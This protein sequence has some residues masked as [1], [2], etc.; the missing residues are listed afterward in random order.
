MNNLRSLYVFELIRMK[1]YNILGASL[2]TSFIFIAVLHFSGVED[3][4]LIFPLLIFLDVTVM[5]ML[6]IGV[7]MFFEK[8]EGTLK[9]MLVSPIGKS[10]YIISK[11]LSNVT[12][13]LLT[14]YTLYGYSVLF[15]ELEVNILLLTLYVILIASFHSLIGIY[16][17]YYKKTF[18]DLLVAIMTYSLALTIPVVLV[19]VG[20]LNIGLIEKMMYLIPT[21]ASML[22]MISVTPQSFEVWELIISL[23]YLIIGGGLLYYIVFRKFDDF[24]VRESGV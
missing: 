12:I 9:T 2:L 8:Q 7:T 4:S 14:L 21:Q 16:I 10:E 11:V 18:T 1:K 15:K 17:T 3:I 22:L 19:Y 13:N 6:L 5:S 24:A 20:I 23:S